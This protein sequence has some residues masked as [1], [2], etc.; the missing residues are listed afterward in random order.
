MKETE[1]GLEENLTFRKSAMAAR[2]ARGWSPT[3]GEEREELLRLLAESLG[4]SVSDAKSPFP[5]AGILDLSHIRLQSM[6]EVPWLFLGGLGSGETR[7]LL[8]EFSRVLRV[9]RLAV[10]VALDDEHAEEGRRFSPKRQALFLTRD[11][12]L[13]L[14]RAG[15][16]R[17]WI[18][19]RLRETFPLLALIPFNQTRPVD[20]HMFFG[21]TFE[22]E[23]LLSRPEASFAIAG[24]EGLGKTSLIRQY[25]RELVRTADPRVASRYYINFLSCSPAESEIARWIGVRIGEGKASAK[26]TGNRDEMLRFLRVQRSRHEG[27]PLELLL[28]DVDDVCQSDTFQALGEAARIG[29]CRLVMAGRSGLLQLMV[30]KESDLRRRLELVRLE[31]LDESAAASLL[32]EPF[33]DLGW[34]VEQ[35]QRMLANV[36]S[37]T[38]QLPHLIQLYGRKISEL[39]IR[40]KLSVVTIEMI[41]EV[42]WDFETVNFVTASLSGIKDNTLKQLAVLLLRS[43]PRH[44]TASTLDHLARSNNIELAEGEGEDCCRRLVLESVLSWSKGDYQISTEA[45]SEYAERQGMFRGLTPRPAPRVK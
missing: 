17:N 45:L 12:L 16:G 35:P 24:P 44:V 25:E 2:L 38:G 21:R 39:M 8:Q 11:D 14:L 10:V 15:D 27:R 29:I 41:E 34:E 28:D 6:D 30:A 13:A 1:L 5:E 36:L 31:P 18:R 7:A 9:G 37:L 23:R 42:K 22:V 3:L 43:K 40:R 19:Q 20:R 32:L 33:G 26:L 4:G